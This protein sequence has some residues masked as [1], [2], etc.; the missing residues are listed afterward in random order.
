MDDGFFILVLKLFYLN[1]PVEYS[2]VFNLGQSAGIIHQVIQGDI[3]NVGQFFGH[4]NK[5]GRSKI[6]MKT[7]RMYTYD[8]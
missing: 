1:D 4:F 6:K 3:K 5:W 7:G 2:L 8:F